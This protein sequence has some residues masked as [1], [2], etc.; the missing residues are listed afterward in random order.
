MVCVD[1]PAEE[2][3]HVLL[4]RRWV[5]LPH[6]MNGGEKTTFC[7]S[8]LKSEEWDREVWTELQQAA[9]RPVRWERL[10]T[11]TLQCSIHSW[12]FTYKYKLLYIQA[13]NILYNRKIRWPSAV[14]IN[15]FFFFRCSLLQI[16]T[17]APMVLWLPLR[18]TNPR[19]QIVDWA[20]YPTDH[21]PFLLDR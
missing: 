2:R 9:A 1:R 16:F 3:N 4:I 18:D 8:I 20:A 12:M 11:I 6:T 17:Y 7:G 5:G 14:A 15:T 21:Y 10:V 19:T 13:Y